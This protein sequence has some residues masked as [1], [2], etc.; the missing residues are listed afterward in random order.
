MKEENNISTLETMG[1]VIKPPFQLVCAATGL[2]FATSLQPCEIHSDE[3]P[4]GWAKRNDVWTIEELLGLYSSKEKKI[5]IFNKGIE[6]IAAQLHVKPFYV[7]HVVRIHEWGHA[8]FHLGLDRTE[9]MQLVD[10]SLNG[11]ESAALTTSN[12]LASIYSSV[13]PH[14]H[15]QIA[16]SITWLALEKLEADAS[17]DGAKKACA[18]LLETFKRLTSR[19]PPQYRLDQFRNFKPN[20][21]QSRLRSFIEL[22]RE[23]NVRGHQKAW[24]TIMPW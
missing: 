18:L 23:G 2:V 1:Q 13:D 11:D 20:Q 9:S 14:V 19:Q 8:A 21:L 15:E 4:P 10:A 24:D 22:I 3:D 7:E 16:Q 6:H 17:V 12:K 5:T